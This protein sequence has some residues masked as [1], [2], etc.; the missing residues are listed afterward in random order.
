MMA[1]L[2]YS[3]LLPPDSAR[4]VHR[5]PGQRTAAASAVS[6]V[7]VPRKHYE[8]VSCTFLRES[9][10]PCDLEPTSAT[11]ISPDRLH[12]VSHCSTSALTL[13]SPG[14]RAIG[15][16]AEFTAGWDVVGPPSFPLLWIQGAGMDSCRSPSRYV[17]SDASCSGSPQVV[18]SVV[19]QNGTRTSESCVTIGVNYARRCRVYR[20]VDWQSSGEKPGLLH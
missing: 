8:C 15:D 14:T 10:G 17:A 20:I 5:F 19:D 12:A 16:I 1:C 3:R 9:A 6:A 7:L 11:S 2:G 4:P 18:T 13:R